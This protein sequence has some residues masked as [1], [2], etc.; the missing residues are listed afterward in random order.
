MN[1]ILIVGDTIGDIIARFLQQDGWPVTVMRKAAGVKAVYDALSET[2]YGAVL[3]T[4]DTM[5]VSHITTM[6]PVISNYFPDV[7]IMVMSGVY[8]DDLVR[9]WSLSGADGFMP[10]PFDGARLTESVRRLLE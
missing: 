10:M 2:S 8:D 1:S 9:S 5:G 3:I 6:V 7:R 4:N